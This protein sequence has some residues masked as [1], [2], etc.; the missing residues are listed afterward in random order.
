M[1]V[2]EPV[3]RG[4][5]NGL[6]HLLALVAAFPREV[7]RVCLLAN[8]YKLAHATPMLIIPRNHKRA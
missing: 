1:G 4:V 3:L 7:C 6:G 8:V 2:R 5:L